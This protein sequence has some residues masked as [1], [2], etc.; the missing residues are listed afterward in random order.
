M[1]NILLLNTAA[2]QAKQMTATSHGSLIQLITW[3][4]SRHGLSVDDVVKQY[5][6]LFPGE[7]HPIHTRGGSK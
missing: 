2:Q 4:A 7:L 1:K 6:K 3:A 5:E